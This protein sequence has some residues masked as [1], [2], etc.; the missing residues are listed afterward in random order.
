[1]SEVKRVSFRPMNKDD[2]VLMLKWLKD[3]CVLE[4]YGGRDEKYTQKEIYAMDQFIGEP[5]YW[6]RG[7]GPEYCRIVC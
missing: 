5:E 2:L 1:M 6:N 4:F 3:D 7:I